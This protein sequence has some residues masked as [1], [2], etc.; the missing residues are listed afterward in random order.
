MGSLGSDDAA[1][2]SELVGYLREEGKLF[3]DLD[4]WDVRADRP[5]LA[6]ILGGCLG[7]EIPHVLMR[8]S[9]GQEDH[10]DRL[11]INAARDLS[12][13]RFGREDLRKRS[14]AEGEAA[15]LEEGAAGEPVT[16][17]SGLIAENGKH[18]R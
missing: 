9:A 3:A 13:R 1:N 18:G 12:R 6:A 8:R 17:F 7:L 14:P 5:K 15:D 10:D 2:K 16:E 4:A 11:V